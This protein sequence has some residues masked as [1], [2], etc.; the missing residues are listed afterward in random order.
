MERVRLRRIVTRWV[1]PSKYFY[2]ASSVGISEKMGV[3][4]GEAIFT[5]YSKYTQS[6]HTYANR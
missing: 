4:N 3:A 5:E 6:P 2:L 1:S